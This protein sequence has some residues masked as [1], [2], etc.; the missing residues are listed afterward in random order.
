METVNQL[1]SD[2]STFIE[3]RLY[4]KFRVIRVHLSQG[5][6]E[7]TRTNGNFEVADSKWPENE[8]I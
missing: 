8:E 2:T 7:L 3:R 1:C 6:V 4:F 5:K